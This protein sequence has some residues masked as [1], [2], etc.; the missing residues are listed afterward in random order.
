M[1]NGGVV[2]TYMEMDYVRMI[3][4]KVAIDGMWYNL[5]FYKEEDGIRVEMEQTVSG[6]MHKV[7]PDNKITDDQFLQT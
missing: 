7:F 1:K 5:Y 2:E 3:I 4:K 6:K